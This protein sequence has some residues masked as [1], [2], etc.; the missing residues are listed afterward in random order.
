MRSTRVVILA[1]LTL[2]AVPARSGQALRLAETQARSGQSE[3]QRLPTTVRPEHYDLAFTVDLPRARFEGTETIRVNVAQPTSRIVLHAFEL[4]L[5]E[6][7][8]GAGA[9]AQKAS[10]T[11]DDNSQTATLTVAQPVERGSADIHIRYTGVLNQQL[12]GFYL[13]KG[14]GRNYAVT[15]FES[16]DAR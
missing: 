10:V 9:A 7:A 1:A 5:H 13:S 15:Q 11:L 2:V 6:V 16:T 4:T 14:Q 12:R 8:I 3:A